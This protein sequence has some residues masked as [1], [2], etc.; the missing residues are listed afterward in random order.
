MQHLVAVKR[1]DASKGVRHTQARPYISERGPRNRGPMAKDRRKML[2]VNP[3][4]VGFEIPYFEARSGRPGA[5]MELARGVTSVYKETYENQMRGDSETRSGY[6]RDMSPSTSSTETSFGDCWGYVPSHPCPLFCRR[7][8]RAALGLER[9]VCQAH[10]C[11]SCD[12]RHVCTTM[13]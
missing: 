11:V 4:T 8:R 9:G 2:R 12:H 6:Q 3:R 13:R 7:K 10:G 5:I 1:G